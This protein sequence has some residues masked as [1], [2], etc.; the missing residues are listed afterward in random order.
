MVCRPDPD[1]QSNNENGLN[2]VSPSAELPV[3]VDINTESF[4]E[5]MS[6]YDNSLLG[7]NAISSQSDQGLSATHCYIV[8]NKETQAGLMPFLCSPI[9]VWYFAANAGSIEL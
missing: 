5:T 4:V 3:K 1:G 6:F 7:L 2:M 8:E 9:V